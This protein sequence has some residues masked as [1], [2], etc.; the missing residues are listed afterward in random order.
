[1]GN[2][3]GNKEEDKGMRDNRER[4]RERQINRKEIGRWREVAKEVQRR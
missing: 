2:R 1:M 4:E 3:E